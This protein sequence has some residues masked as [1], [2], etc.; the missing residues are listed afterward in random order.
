LGDQWWVA[1][2]TLREADA[3]ADAQRI[4]IA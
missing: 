4:G 1:V 2:A 3:A